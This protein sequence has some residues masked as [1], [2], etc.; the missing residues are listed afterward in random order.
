MPA[1]NSS[2]LTL[3]QRKGRL[4]ELPERLDPARTALIVIDLQNDFCHRDGVF[5]K[6][7]FDMS[8]MDPAIEQTRRLVAE[9]REQRLLII[10]VR[11]NE[12]GKYLSVPM[13]ETYHRR[14]FVDGLAC[15]NSWGADW[16]MDIRPGETAN[17]ID[18]IKYRFG[19]FEDTPLDLYLRSNGITTLVTAGVITSGCVESTVRNAFWQGYAVV[20]PSDCVADASEERHRASLSKMAA[21]FGDVV[22]AEKIIEIWR[23]G[24][25]ANLRRWEREWK[26]TQAMASL[27][28]KTDPGHTA[29]ILID[30]HRSDGT[31]G[32]AP[33]AA[34]DRLLTRARQHGIMVVHVRTEHN[35]VSISEPMFENGSAVPEAKNSA[36][37]GE[38]H[39]HSR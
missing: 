12:D 24:K 18:F 28:S 20:V 6:L 8:W 38:I 22:P 32:S 34:I 4:V 27:A 29:L 5:G 13:A 2:G 25:P 33:L 1:A 36:S 16:Y 30:A 31:T 39:G 23:G 37:S 35:A 11:G 9:A 19:A 21:S 10:F 7:G 14:G 26:S 3:I 15:R 17:E